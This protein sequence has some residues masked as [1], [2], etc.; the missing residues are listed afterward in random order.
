MDGGKVSFMLL[1]LAHADG[2]EIGG[3]ERGGDVRDK[4]SGESDVKW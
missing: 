4:K 1:E 2:E 3:G